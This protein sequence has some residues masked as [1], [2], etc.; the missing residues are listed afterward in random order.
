VSLLLLLFPRCCVLVLCVVFRITF[1]VP[2]NF[3]RLKNYP[4]QHFGGAANVLYEFWFLW[5][6][7]VCINFERVETYLLA[8]LC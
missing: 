5:R 7:V 6:L 8:Q 1:V 3:E 2:T 4:P